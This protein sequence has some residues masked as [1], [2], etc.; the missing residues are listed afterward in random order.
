MKCG[1]RESVKCGGRESM[2]CDGKENEVWRARKVM[3]NV[4]WQ[5]EVTLQYAFMSM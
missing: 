2:K 1:G 4:T 3:T 5:E